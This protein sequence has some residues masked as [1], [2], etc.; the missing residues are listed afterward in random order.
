[1]GPVLLQKTI[2][3]LDGLKKDKPRPLLRFGLIETNLAISPVQ[4]NNVLSIS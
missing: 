4:P 2:K 3:F 1:M